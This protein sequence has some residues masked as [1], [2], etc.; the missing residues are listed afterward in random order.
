MAKLA[1]VMRGVSLVA[2][3]LHVIVSFV[4]N[5]ESDIVFADSYCNILSSFIEALG[6][7]RWYNI[8]YR[9]IW[10]LK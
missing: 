5:I 9:F 10:L 8:G 6:I 1:L 7:L 3:C 4:D 2:S